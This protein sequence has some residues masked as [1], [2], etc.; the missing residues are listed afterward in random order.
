M[1]GDYGMIIVYA[2]CF[3]LCFIGAKYSIKGFDK[4]GCLSMETTNSI[5][6]LFIMLV[7]LS[8]FTQYYTYTAEIDIL[9]KRISLWLG[10]LIV[11][12]FMF[13]SGYG[14]LESIK[15]KGSGYVSSFPK[16]R[17]LKTLVHFDLAVLIFFIVDLMLGKIGT[18]YDL[19]TILLAFVGWTG[20]GNSN[21]YIF[22][23]LILYITTFVGF[24]V[25][26][27]NN[28]LAAVLSTVLIG[29]YAVVVSR[30]QQYWWYDTVL[31][32]ALGMWFSLFKDKI[33]AFVTKNNFIWFIATAAV[34]GACIFS[35]YRGNDIGWK[36][37]TAL[38]FALFM[39]FGSLKFTVHNKVLAWLGKHTFEIYILMRLPMMLFGRWGLK[40][41]NVYLYFF[42][43]L[44]AT[45]AISAVFGKCMGIIDKRL[46]K[47]KQLA[48]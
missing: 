10:Q 4:S 34:T 25:F 38:F 28:Y 23:V 29:A 46:F 7:F 16:N 6:G 41:I 8:H 1:K 39:V 17:V 47:K 43:C 15:K 21:W 37:S 31:C 2:V 36:I 27:K 11:V 30:Y 35:H 20:I 40:D 5:R 9:G 26:K 13:Y 48:A 3:I 19:K 33:L 24:T 45:L 14:V 44:V 22:A 12:M 42:S 18:T 32:Y